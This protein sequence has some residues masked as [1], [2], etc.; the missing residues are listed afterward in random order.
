MHR[1]RGLLVAAGP[2]IR[3]DERIYGASLLDVAPTLLALCGV[4]PGE[5]F[6]GRPLVEILTGELALERVPS[7]E[8]KSGSFGLPGERVEA[9]E[10]F[11]L[12]SG[13]A[14]RALRYNL[15]R[16]LLGA[17]RAEEACAVLEELRKDL[18]D[19][20]HLA[21]LH[22]QAAYAAGELQGC[23]AVLSSLDAASELPPMADVLRGFLAFHEGRTEEAVERLERAEESGVRLPRLHYEIGS[24]YLQMGLPERAAGAFRRALE[25]DGGEA[26]ARDGLAATLLELDRPEE[27][28]KEALHAVWLS[29]DLAPAHFH[30]GAAL[31]RLGE[32]GRAIEA[33]ETCLSLD[34]KAAGAHLWLARLYESGALD[35]EKALA[36]RAKAQEILDP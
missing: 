20:A 19:E 36:H 21:V 34:E 15:A 14:A 8:S 16:A 35:L 7:W 32:H 10:D 25:I 31:A 30:L 29:H 2:G 6:E 22:A 3:E 28:A 9:F 13:N 24:A 18:P 27:A 1:A 12:A 11:P 17:E 23:R 4:P 5:D 33:F 26:R